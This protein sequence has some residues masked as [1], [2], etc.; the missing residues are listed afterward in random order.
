M[1]NWSWKLGEPTQSPQPPRGKT[2]NTLRFQGEDQ[3][4][5][6]PPATPI[7]LCPHPGCG[8]AR[9][10]GLLVRLATP[11]PPQNAGF[12]HSRPS[13]KTYQMNEWV[14]D[15]VPQGEGSRQKESRG[16]HP[17]LQLPLPLEISQDFLISGPLPLP[18]ISKELRHHPELPCL[19]HLLTM[20]GPRGSHAWPPASSTPALSLAQ[21]PISPSRLSLILRQQRILW[22]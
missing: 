8:P 12:S 1:P 18:F 22:R 4:P 11:H 9:T 13:M 17:L 7:H 19:H 5:S 10:V 15:F 21:L 6:L 14:R 3:R 2:R 20:S 16:P